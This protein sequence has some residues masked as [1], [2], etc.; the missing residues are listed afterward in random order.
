MSKRNNILAQ[1]A[2]AA[3]IAAWSGSQAYATLT[4]DICLAG[5]TTLA[6][7]F[8]A[9][10][11]AGSQTF[12]IYAVITGPTTSA[13]FVVGQFGADLTWSSAS[14]SGATGGVLSGVDSAFHAFD[15]A[16]GIQKTAVNGLVSVGGT[17]SF[18]DVG[19]IGPRGASASAFGVTAYSNATLS[20]YA[21][22]VGTISAYVSGLASTDTLQ[23]TITPRLTT[24]VVKQV[25]YED[26]VGKGDLTLPVGIG[27]IVTITNVPTGPGEWKGA[28]VPATFNLAGNWTGGS[29]PGTS[30]IAT[31]GTRNT[32]SGVVTMDS[33][34]TVQG[35]SFAS[36]NSY[37]ITAAGGTLTVANGASPTSITLA[38]ASHSILAPLALS[39]DTTVSSD[40]TGHV[41]TAGNI[42]IASGKTLTVAA[43]TNMVANQI[44]N[45]GL[46][47]N[48]NL[49]LTEFG[50]SN[51]QTSGV[52][53]VLDSLSIASGK[54]F[55]LNDRDVIVHNAASNY[56]WYM[57]KLYSG[58]AFGNWTGTGITSAAAAADSSAKTLGLMTG[59]EFIDTYGA[60][61]LFDGHAVSASDILIKYT[62]VGDLN[63]DGIVD[64]NDLGTLLGPYDSTQAVP[65][66]GY[67]SGDLN[68]DGVIDDND[69]GA[70]LGLYNSDGWPA[71]GLQTL[72]AHFGQFG[73]V[74]EPASLGL[75]GLGA[76][77]LLT[78]KR[79]R[80]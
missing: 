54:T 40:T 35:V 19:W 79:R 77:A 76:L 48:G 51:R 39:S 26:G 67:A 65:G 12:D 63:L 60:S 55:D 75:V 66:N 41:F 31:F 64:D 30:D 50:T 44:T 17:S 4:Y 20:G 9:V 34:R 43:G 52:V 80:A 6:T 61:A 28:A 10:G 46:V 14:G 8:N 71:N 1:A 53:T 74:P 73:A 3:A 29:I 59:A 72:S 16:N 32:I 37:T 38:Q 69:L 57:G 25:W 15:Y 27:N 62:Y 49:S 13:S 47:L 2:L 33:N 11:G 42:T 7:N 45:G 22:M 70:L 36:P 18:S 56:S 23:L 5:T 58:S 78:R 24:N 68:F 21:V